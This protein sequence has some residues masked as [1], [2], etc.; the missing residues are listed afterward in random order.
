M[1]RNTL[2][3][4][5]SLACLPACAPLSFALAPGA[6]KVRVTDVAGDV[7]G[8]TPIGNIQVPRDADGFISTGIAA[9]QFAN[10]VVGYG[11]NAGFVTEGTPRWPKAGIAYHCP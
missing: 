9:G 7:A 6:E 11:G 1:L 3:G 2:L 8:C 5:V 10:Q 4:V